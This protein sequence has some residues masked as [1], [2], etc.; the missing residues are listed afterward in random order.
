MAGDY[1]YDVLSY[2]DIG[3]MSVN[4]LSVTSSTLPNKNVL[5]TYRTSD[6]TTART[7]EVKPSTFSA[8]RVNRFQQIILD[9]EE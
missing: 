3:S 5:Y 1:D 4:V 9:L 8:I 7:V 2:I 6:G